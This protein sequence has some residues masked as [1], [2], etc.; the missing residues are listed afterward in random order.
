MVAITCGTGSF[1]NGTS[2]SEGFLR[3][4]GGPTNPRGGIAGIGTATVGTHTRYNNCI[5]YGIFRGLLWEDQFTLGAALTRGKLEMYLNYHQ[6]QPNQVTIWS[7]WNSL[8]GDPALECWTGFPEGLTVHYPTEIPVG[9]NAVSVTV[10][11]GGFPEASTQV[12]LLRDNETHVVGF[13]DGD[14]VVTL[15]IAAESAGEM[16]ITATKHNRHPFLGSIPI[17]TESTYVGFLSAQVDDDAIGGSAGN[18]DGELNPGETVELLVE[19]KNFGTETASGVT[20]TLT[21]SD[22]YVTIVD[23]DE[24]FGDLAGGAAAWSVDDFDFLI[25]PLCPHG[26]M[27]RLGLD[28][29]SGVNQWHSIIDLP[30]VSADLQAEGFTLYDAG[31]NGLFDPGETITIGVNLRNHGGADAIDVTGT[32]SSLSPF[33]TVPDNAGSWDD[34]AVG[35]IIE[36]GANRF[37]LTASPDTY[38]E[39]LVTLLLVTEFGGG[40][41]DTTTVSL[42]IGEREADDPIGPDAYGYFAFDNTDVAYP[43]APTYEWIEIDPEFGGQG[44][45]VPLTDFETYA[46]DSVVIDLPFPFAYYGQI[47]EQ[48][49]VCSSGWLAMGSTWL[50]HYRNWTILGAGGPDGFLSVFWD[51]LRLVYGG[52]VYQDYDEEN[53][54]FIVEWSRVR[55][56]QGG[57]QTIEII[58]YDPAHHLTESGDGIIVFQYEDVTNSDTVDNYATVG[59]ESPDGRDGILYSY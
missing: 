13:T 39:I 47:Y 12:C 43:E 7:Y 35:M 42:T 23:A 17:V 31:E 44:A 36:N 40:L 53:H 51:D 45:L 4:N 1:A 18:G 41:S 16:L 8:M 10:E 52:R 6:T 29:G 48:A 21:C 15:P 59:I 26:R 5:H 50:T 32:L 24:S 9:S 58:P 2:R 38:E 46:D 11:R 37:S 34:I 33:V 20:A 55:N 19:L 56:E 57:L 25:D 22:P 30:V 3:A 54:R 49:T 14:G 27:I 28:I